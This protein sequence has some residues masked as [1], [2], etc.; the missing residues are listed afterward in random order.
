[1]IKSSSSKTVKATGDADRVT[2]ML[3]EFSYAEFASGIEMLQAA[4][5][6]NDAKLCNGFIHHALDEYRHSGI[7]KSL[8][9][10]VDGCSA[11]AARKFRFIPR[12]AGTLGYLD[13]ENFSIEQM[14][15]DKFA[16][17]VG[18]NE[19]E[20]LRSFKKRRS[21]LEKHSPKIAKYIDGIIEDEHRHAGYSFAY[22]KDK[23]KKAVRFLKFKEKMFNLV[24]H[25]YGSNRKVSEPVALVILY[26]S[27]I[28]LLPFRFAFNSGNSDVG[29]NLMTADKGKSL[30]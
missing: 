1:M 20:A 12:L 21:E 14:E 8:S 19:E 17:F 6:V 3:C 23:P 24:R 2:Q 27:L 28:L 29:Q 25:V 11:E 9:E 10:Q 7:F 26:F 5:Y 16:I 22:V 13:P 18:T 4:K 15:L 30:L